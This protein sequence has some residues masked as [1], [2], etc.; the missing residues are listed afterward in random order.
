MKNAGIFSSNKYD[1]EKQFQD[2]AASVMFY[3]DR[4]YKVKSHEKTIT[5]GDIVWR[6]ILMMDWDDCQKI[7]G[8]EFAAIFVDETIP[9]DCKDF[10]KSRWRFQ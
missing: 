5:I 2:H 3:E 9:R 1:L 8:L 6:Y 10:I 7:A 4:A